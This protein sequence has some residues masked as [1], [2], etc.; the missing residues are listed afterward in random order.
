MDKIDKI[1]FYQLPKNLNMDPCIEKVRQMR[2]EAYR[3][4]RLSAQSDVQTPTGE[5]ASSSEDS[6]DTSS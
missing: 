3:K 5:P 4:I 6:N 1:D 2:L